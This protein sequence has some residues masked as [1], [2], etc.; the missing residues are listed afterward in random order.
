[1]V[2][3][4]GLVGIGVLVVVNAVLAALVTR[5]CRTRLETDWGGAVYAVLGGGL[6]LVVSTLVLSGIF[7]VG[8]DLG[9]QYNAMLVTVVVPLALGIT[10]DYFWMPA[11]EDVELPDSL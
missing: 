10:F 11:P 5:V 7:G 6:V 1:M 3:T 8:G 2:S 4:I 9:S